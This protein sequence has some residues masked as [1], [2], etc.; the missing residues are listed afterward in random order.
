MHYMYYVPGALHGVDYTYDVITRRACI[1]KASPATGLCALTRYRELLKESVSSRA[2]SARVIFSKYMYF[3]HIY[4]PLPRSLNPTRKSV[5]FECKCIDYFETQ[6][7]GYTYAENRVLQEEDERKR[8][9]YLYDLFV[10]THI[11]ILGY[12]AHVDVNA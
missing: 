3:E 1:G 8:L 6:L 10:I 5:Y 7:K 12:Y 2:S 4:I 9:K 11:K